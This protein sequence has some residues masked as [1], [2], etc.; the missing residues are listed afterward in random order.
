M[1]ALAALG[2]HSAGVAARIVSVPASAP[3]KI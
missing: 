1:S 3:P 2:E